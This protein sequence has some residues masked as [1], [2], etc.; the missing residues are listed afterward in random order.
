MSRKTKPGKRSGDLGSQD[1]LVME[2]GSWRRRDR[3]EQQ[4]VGRNR[5]GKVAQPGKA[6]TKPVAEEFQRRIDALK[7]A[8]LAAA[9]EDREE[10]S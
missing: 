2:D 5:S 6:W 10:K 9:S 4:E 1:Y 3:I 8:A 7:V